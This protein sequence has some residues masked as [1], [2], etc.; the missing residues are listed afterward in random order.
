MTTWRDQLHPASF[1]GVA[2]LVDSDATP[3]GRRVQVH[4]YPQRDKPLVEDM[5]SK[6]REIKLTAFI[7]GDDCLD[8]RDDLLNA[9]DKPGAGELVH[10]WFGR[11]L[12]TAGDGCQV[13]HERREG[14]IV[15]FEL[16]FIEGGEKGYPVGVPKASR[17][18]EASSESFLESA[19]ARYKAAMAVVNRA[20]MAVTALQNSIAGIQMAIQR[21]FSQVLGLVSSAEA[22]ADMLINAPGNFS[23][24]IRAQFSSVGG[25]TR[26]SGYSWSP[27]S[28]S[29][30][31]VAADPEFANTV[32]RLA[33]T[34]EVFSGFVDSGRGI[35][36]QLELARQLM[37]EQQFDDLMTNPP[38]GLATAAAVK[39]ARELMRDALIVKAVRAAALMPVVSAPAELPGVPALAQQVASPL[40]RPEV[41]AADDVISLRDG[42]SAALWEAGL[43][44]SHEHFEVIE[45]VRKH[46]KGHLSEVARSGVRL[47]EIEPKESLP[48]LVL[49]YQ[50]FGDASRAAEIVTRNKVPHPGFLPVGVLHIAQ[51]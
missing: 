27:S 16:V 24:M 23:A 45:A 28:S 40:E 17:Q 38:G 20:R 8:R 47:V 42:L 43:S 46:V 4:E 29:S 21:E 44:A 31:T 49:A 26:S 14:G 50:C 35:T 41:P 25:S 19:L 1:R 15:R 6:T 18:V 11:L 33:S 36:S 7:G 22:L 34:E 51:E 32:A 48:A 39:A 10:P 3:V 2:F 37:A 12:V 5:G 30:A 13:S 9:L